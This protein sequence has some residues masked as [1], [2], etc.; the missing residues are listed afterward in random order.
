MFTKTRNQQNEVLFVT[1][2]PPR[3]CG[4]ATYSKD[5]IDTVQKKFS[6]FSIN[7]CALEE[8]HTIR[9][10][11][12]NVKYIFRTH[13][14]EAYI[15]MGEQINS[16]DA[17][18]MVFIQHEFGLFGGEY[19]EYL[20]Q[21][22][23]TL[24]KPISATFHTVLPNPD[25]RRRRIVQA[26]VNTC[27]K[28]VVMTKCSSEILQEEYGVSEE[29][30]SVIPHGTHIVEWK[31]KAGIKRA[32][33][34]DRRLVLS[35]FGLLSSNKSIETALDAMP[36]IVN[37]FP[38]V[39]YLILGKT[40]PGV[41]RHEGEAY[42]QFLEAKVEELGLQDNV[43]FVNK[44]LELRKL[45]EYL[46]L[47]DIYL[48]TSKD[49][50]QAVS[51]T[52]AYAMNSA[53]PV[54]STPIPH[55]KEM[56]SDNAGVIIDF[57]SPTQ[58]ANAAIRLLGN[59]ELREE[60]GRNAFSQTRTTVWENIAIAHAKLFNQIGMKNILSWQLPKIHLEHIYSLTTNFGMIQFSDIWNPD[61]NSGYTLDDNA[62]AMIALCMHYHQT[63]NPED[64]ELISTYLNFIEYCQQSNGKFLNY[65]DKDRE[66]SVQNGYTNLEDSNGRAVWALGVLIAHGYIL[67]APL[68]VKAEAIF[69]KA[70][71]HIPEIES[72]RAIAFV[73]KGL[74]FYQSTGNER[75]KE[76]IDQLA[77]KLVDK[78][79][80]VSDNN[81][82]WFED[83]MTYAN[84]TLPEAMLYAYLATGNSS[85][86]LIAHISFEFLLSHLFIDGK[87]K[88][89]SNRGW[90]HKGINPNQHGEQPID[91]SYT[92]QALDIFYKVFK[93]DAYR[94][95]MEIAF[96]WFLGNNQLDQ[97]LYN[98]LTGGSYDGLEEDGVN[99]NQG[100]ESS[101][102]Y[103][104]AR[105]TMEKVKNT[106]PEKRPRLI[107]RGKELVYRT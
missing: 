61:V 76:I 89:I 79:H 95:K 106:L 65:V 77:A 34:L 6:S 25:E 57:Q 41:A 39:L 16:D 37:Q 24:N 107:Q 38:N 74:Y 44:Y 18:K 58:L 13:D 19:G 90:Y 62:R 40:H 72:P 45:L 94:E 31:N 7:V 10:Y 78:Y 85:Y 101:V 103:L 36:E 22:L 20:L 28:I 59:P 21:F 55:A 46:L 83:Y 23:Y 68:V 104:I 48:F 17:V 69:E 14:K 98:P 97:I 63:E 81:W 1:S 11:P 27:D 99:L 60:M 73:I 56:L 75:I 32:Y 53:C 64:F 30:I 12:E 4:I 82:K 9:D 88:V 80:V 8:G 92:I 26:I 3:A 29:K 2:Y 67:P 66:F 47:T 33:Q 105:L 71:C 84:S 42:R 102:C 50:H 91:V 96:S 35:T 54:I 52:F 100:A 15:E 49:P 51:G 43:H 87:I 93:D 5:L 70:I 86:K